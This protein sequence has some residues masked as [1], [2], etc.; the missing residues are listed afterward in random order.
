MVNKPSVFEPVKFY[1]IVLKDIDTFRTKKKKPVEFANNAH[2]VMLAQMFKIYD[3][4]KSEL[5][6]RRGN[7]DNLGIIIH[8]SP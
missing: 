7:R 3:M 5:Q 8:I 4:C 2:P 1:C 6:I